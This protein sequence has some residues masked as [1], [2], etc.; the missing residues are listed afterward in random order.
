LG[1]K[2]RAT[3]IVGQ[4]RRLPSFCS[5]MNGNRQ[6]TPSFL[7]NPAG[8]AAAYVGREGA[9]VY[10]QK[11]SIWWLPFIFTEEESKDGQATESRHL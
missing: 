6:T 4:A 3:A 1:F 10:D 8:Y 9:F 7:L 2:P 5:V 11:T